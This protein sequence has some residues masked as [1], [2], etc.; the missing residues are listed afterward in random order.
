M[1]RAHEEAKKRIAGVKKL[2]KDIQDDVDTDELRRLLFSIL[3]GIVL[4]LDELDARTADL[5][6]EV[7]LSD[8]FITDDDTP[9]QVT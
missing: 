6:R 8:S 3:E 2:V 5:E 1:S 9:K 4:E 7:G